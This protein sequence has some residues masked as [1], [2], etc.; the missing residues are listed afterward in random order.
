MSSPLVP[1][2]G[3]DWLIAP[4]GQIPHGRRRWRGELDATDVIWKFFAAHPASVAGW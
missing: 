4:S 1:W 2:L 3:T